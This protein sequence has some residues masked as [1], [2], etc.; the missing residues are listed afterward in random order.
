MYEKKPCVVLRFKGRQRE[1]KFSCN[2]WNLTLNQIKN[3]K[4]FL[5]L[6]KPPCYPGLASQF[7]FNSL[8][9]YGGDESV[10]WR[11]LFVYSCGKQDSVSTC[12][13]CFLF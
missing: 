11:L 2:L 9:F 6:V 3:T 5:A 1:I 10:I 8:A 7:L 4:C 13:F 12:K